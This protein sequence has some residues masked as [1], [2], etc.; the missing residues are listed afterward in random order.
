M[1]ERADA[2]SGGIDPRGPRFGAALTSVLL[3]AAVVLG[4][5][6]LS[7]AQASFGWFA[8]QP[9]ADTVLAPEGWAVTQATVAERALDPG[10]LLLLVAVLLFLWGVL[11]PRTAPWAALFR[12]MVQPRLTPALDLEDPRPPRFA[13]GV[14][15]AVTSVG[16]TLHLLGVP[17]AVPVAAATALIASLLN[18]V[19]GLCLGCQMYLLLQRVGIVGR[20]RPASDS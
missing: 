8:Y 12:T 20:A 13:Q 18:A 7:T 16:V 10:F 17:W 14:G 19:F 6:G 3:G 15:L 5:V 4:L 11:S 2:A 9:L 1:A